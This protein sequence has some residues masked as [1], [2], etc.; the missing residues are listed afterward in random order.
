MG[1]SDYNYRLPEFVSDS[2]FLKACSGRDIAHT[3][4]IINKFME[5]VKGFS[6]HEYNHLCEDILRDY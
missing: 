1:E 3:F 6:E 4:Y 5:K 2:D